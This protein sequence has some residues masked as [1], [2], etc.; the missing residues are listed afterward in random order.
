FLNSLGRGENALLKRSTGYAR[1]ESGD[2]QKVLNPQQMAVVDAIA[3]DLNSG[4]ELSA[5]DVEGMREALNAIRASENKEIRVPNLV[6][7]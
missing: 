1:Y 4:I 7:Y 5:R 2:L 6:N 3:K